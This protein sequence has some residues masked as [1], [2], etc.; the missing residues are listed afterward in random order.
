VKEGGERGGEGAGQLKGRVGG[1]TRESGG[2]GGRKM[3]GVWRG[4][5]RVY[6]Q[7]WEEGSGGMECGPI[8]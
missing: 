5:G 6:L 4:A 1:G 8:P 3:G 7:L 2:Q